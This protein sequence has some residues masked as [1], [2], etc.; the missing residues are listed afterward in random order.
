MITE[1]LV[2]R[3]YISRTTIPG[4][5]SKSWPDP[6]RAFFIQSGDHLYLFHGEAGDYLFKEDSVSEIMEQINTGS[7]LKLGATPF[8]EA[9]EIIYNNTLPG[10]VP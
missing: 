2:Y 5:F 7:A 8:S 6:K 3:G 10:S 9:K 1:G 4:L